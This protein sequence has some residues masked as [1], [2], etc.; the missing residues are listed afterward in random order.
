MAARADRKEPSVARILIVDD[1]DL[2]SLTLA[3]RLAREGHEA[4]FVLTAEEALNRI[5]SATEPF[6]I[7]LID[8]RLGP[9]MDG[10]ELLRQARAV[11][12]NSDAVL[13][14][15]LDEPGV[16]MLAYQAGAYRYLHK[17]FESQ[18]LILIIQSLLDWRKTDY[19]RNWLSILNAVV[20]E[21]Q[22]A[23]TVAEVG[24]ALV[25]GGIR[26]GFDRA[27]FYQVRDVDGTPSLIGICQGGVN[28]VV[29]FETIVRSMQQ[30]KYS[31]V[32]YEQRAPIFFHSRELGTSFLS[33]YPTQDG[34]PDSFGEWA[35]IPLSSGES[36][37][38]IL[39]LDNA[40][41]KGTIH[42]QQKDLLRLFAGQAVSALERALRYEQDR[43]ERQIENL[44]RKIIHQMGNPA[45]KDALDRLLS[46][47]RENFLGREQ[48][49]NFIVALQDKETG[50]YRYRLHIENGVPFPS[51]W[52]AP[53]QGGLIEYVM[54]E[55]SPLFLASNTAAFRKDRGIAQVG[56]NPAHSWMGVP[57]RIGEDVIGAVVMENDYR[58]YAFTEDQF[59]SFKHLAG[60][61]TSV[62]QAA[63]LNEQ[64]REYS[65]LLHQLQ[66]ASE[67][68]PGFNEEKLWWTTL[69]LCTADYGAS[70][71]R[72]MLFLAEEDK[73]RLRGR[74]AVGHLKKEDAEAD[75]EEYV[76]I[77]M[78][79]EKFLTTLKSDELKPTPLDDAVRDWAFAVSQGD[80][81][82]E[83]L[84][85][86]KFLSVSK[87][88]AQNRLPADFLARFG[89]THY[90]LVPVNAGEQMVGV[91]VLD[92]IWEKDPNRLGVLEILDNLTNQ[93]ALLAEN[94]H[95]SKALEDL[96]AL[97]HDVL[98]QSTVR[99]LQETLQR[100][101][102]AAKSIA[103]ADLAAIYPLQDNGEE[104]RYD[105]RYSAR[106]GRRNL[107]DSALSHTPTGLSRYALLEAKEPV[108]IEDV[109]A[110]ETFYG[111]ERHGDT[112]IVKDEGIR[113]TIA[114]PVFGRRTGAAR[115]MF[116]IDYHTPRAFSE[117]DRRIAEAF[118]HLIATA[119]RNWRD[120]QGLRDVRE[121]QDKELSRLSEV[122]Q[123]ALAAESDERQ[124]AQLLLEKIP[125]LFEPLPVT[126]GITLREWQRSTADDEPT[127]IYRFIY[128]VKNGLKDRLIQADEKS[129]VNGRAVRTGILQNV[130]D[131]SKDNDYQ[132]RYQ[133]Y[134]DTKSELDVPIWVDGQ[135]VG[136]LNIES[137]QLA[138]FTKHHEEMGQ[139]FADIAA[140]AIGNV[141]RQRNLR[142]VFSAASALTGPTRFR[143]TLDTI[144]STVRDAIPNLSLLVIWYLDPESR[145]PRLGSYFGVS[146]TA[147]QRESPRKEGAVQKGL[148]LIK[149]YYQP[150]VVN[151]ILF[152]GRSFVNDEGIVSTAIFPL[153]VQD[154]AVGVMFFS[155]RVR[156]E[157]TD[158]E[159]R[160]FPILAEV[161]ASSINDALQLYHT[162]REHKRLRATQEV[163]DVISSSVTAEQVITQCH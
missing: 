121:A 80:A 1:D 117:H 60:H 140:L 111:G 107:P 57:L 98:V 151:D 55:K 134:E 82:S 72:A 157:F 79:W 148:T 67:L 90:C 93:A 7:L 112:A 133:G 51:S 53:T 76:R 66:E 142:T 85:N 161:V 131:V 30:T 64:E 38:G 115:A 23:N 70:F 37:I 108:L 154:K 56:L 103:G 39:N 160:L 136:A 113:A 65:Q 59:N 143:D 29:G 16:G 104:L 86:N 162:E 147:I 71:D 49:D 129:G 95:K 43:Q 52:R 61:L 34:S 42:P 14:T 32:A 141:R 75:W 109:M 19:E 149:P 54:V 44:A 58:N 6:E 12:L 10:I 106:V 2:W 20:E 50:W 138:V 46:A 33:E 68:I 127:E 36:C 155:Y 5:H 125:A 137:S 92:N 135:V 4:D 15:G 114:V 84:S 120:A 163:T 17:P 89:A 11:S 3:R 47:I 123:S 73:T 102:E 31:K 99:S 22:R 78:N 69:T 158:E 48:D 88:N 139:R 116:Y 124:I 18:E 144:A 132:P 8:H 150:D 62:I 21:L 130:A 45:E 91:V 145:R 28:Q 126:T 87:E 128:P 74:M 77:G 24:R 35:S 110:D 119:I 41:R 9:G 118:A 101:C 96:I 152:Q 159:R 146:K 156:H 81:F 83:V 153:R 100:I 63:W 105:H 25:D 27:R 94:L 26:L 40:A 122:L 97:Q 13:F